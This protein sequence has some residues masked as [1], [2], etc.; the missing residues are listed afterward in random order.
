MLIM[1]HALR[2]PARSHHAPTLIAMLFKLD[3]F[4]KPDCDAG[5]RRIKPTSTC[6]GE[7]TG[8]IE[9][10]DMIYRSEKDGCHTLRNNWHRTRKA[11]LNHASLLAPG[12]VTSCTRAPPGR[13]TSCARCRRAPRSRGWRRP[14]SRRTPTPARRA[15]AA[16]SWTATASRRRR[17]GRRRSGPPSGG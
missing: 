8:F 11:W 4:F 9:E 7:N 10:C 14:D 2:A 16:P 3:A 13:V 15:A 12:R 1:L 17:T 6:R 5:Y